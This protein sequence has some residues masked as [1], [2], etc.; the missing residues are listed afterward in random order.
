MA[1][2]PNTPRGARRVGIAAKITAT[3][4]AAALTTLIVGGSAVLGAS[5]LA[6]ATQQMYQRNVQNIAAADSMNYD[7]LNIRYLTASSILLA[8]SPDKAK[9]TIKQRDGVIDKVRSDLKTFLATPGLTDK[10]IVLAKEAGE[11][12]EAYVPPLHQVEALFAQNKPQEATAMRVS[13]LAPLGEKIYANLSG[14]A[15]LQSE[16]AKI[17]AEEA[18]AA[19]SLVL[20]VI[21]GVSL[22]GVLI[23]LLASRMLA[24]NLISAMHRIGEVSRALAKGDLSKRAELNRGDELGKVSADLDQG[25]ESIHRLIEDVSDTAG[26][27]TTAVSSLQD[28][29][30][31]IGR[32]AT[33]ASQAAGST[34]QE[35]SLLSDNVQTVAAGSQEMGASIQA[36]SKNAAEAAR[37]A[38]E[39]TEKAARTNDTVQK[40][41][42]SSQE[43]G[44]VIKTITSIAEQTN[45]LALNA[46]IEAARAGEAGKGF[47]VVA[48]EVK[49][50][51]QETSKATED[52]A[53]RIE[54][55]Q[56]DSNGA[57]DA[58]AEIG[59]IIGSI[60]DYQTTIASAV[61]E[62]S[63]TTDEMNR[64]VEQA[65]TGSASIADMLGTIATAAQN[66]KDTTSKMTEEF[67]DLA[68][69]SAELERRVQV[70]TL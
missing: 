2:E 63:A 12:L 9:A 70:F 58:I 30:S 35:A 68:H 65:A 28:S 16:Q 67:V 26:R 22:L 17:A 8:T 24:R 46:T 7:Y 21:G 38:F 56:G 36:I 60:N 40:L 47:A 50:L 6:D 10:E 52:I 25:M 53:R 59:R 43:I 69:Q 41:G 62:Q 29:C 20:M 51:A 32:D 55:I 19:R 3:V 39:A 5:K 34:A 54:T 57:V 4:G 18:N 13:T 27:V 31:A 49:E 48:N 45:L 14:L 66:S 64:N 33:G 42:T 11:A 44:E 23:T 61:E 37:V 15:Q 1:P